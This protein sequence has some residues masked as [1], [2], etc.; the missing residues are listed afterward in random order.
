[1]SRDWNPEQA[2][3]IGRDGHVFVSAGAGTGKTAVLVERVL[4]RIDAGTSLDAILVITF[5]DRAASELKARIRAALELRGDFDRARAVDT[6]WISTIHRFCTRILRGHA[7]A[8]G[9]DPAVHRHRRRRGPDS[10]VRGLRH[11]PG[12]VPVGDRPGRVAATRPAGRLLAATPARAAAGGLRT[13]AQR[14]PP[15]R[16]A[17]ARR[18]GY[19]RRQ[20][21]G[22]R[23][24]GRLRQ[25][26]VRR[27]GRAARFRRGRLAAVGSEPLQGAPGGGV[28][29][30][31]PGPRGSR[32][33]RPRR[34]R[35]VRP[36]P[37]R[38]AA[39][40]VCPGVPGAEG[41]ALAGR[42]QRPRVARRRAAGALA[43]ARPRVP[44]ALRR[45][46]GGR[47]P[48]HQPAAGRADRP[49]RG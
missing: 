6:A 38:R 4:R 23:H 42:L 36:G 7:I 16:S 26:R 43:R 46:D 32:T 30:V 27:A 31:R 28:C 49:D 37:A 47:V 33:G 41:P 21:G 11:R 15:A 20:G 48:G 45:G 14:R 19:R 22:A 18:A 12:A 13:P 1:M 9:L 44:G 35:G 5:T 8:A 40:G 24:R 3:A 17:A 34:R 29:R 39:Q 25:G 10:A 2:E